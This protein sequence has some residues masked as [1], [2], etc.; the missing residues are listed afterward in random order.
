MRRFKRE[1]K[2]INPPIF[3][4]ATWGARV[5][6]TI[7]ICLLA[8]GASIADG[9]KHKLSKDL[10]ALKGGSKGPTVDIIVQFNQAPTDAQHSKVEGKGGL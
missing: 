10:N 4:A 7:V 1:K 2:L 6:V 3:S 9:K 5:L 8:A